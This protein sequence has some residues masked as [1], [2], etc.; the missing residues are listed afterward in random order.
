MFLLI[1]AEF[2]YLY[3]A[4]IAEEVFNGIF[5]Y[6]SQ[7]DKSKATKTSSWNFAY[8]SVTAMTFS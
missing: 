4:A 5:L 1:L 6:I 7:Q 8:S 2:L 3:L